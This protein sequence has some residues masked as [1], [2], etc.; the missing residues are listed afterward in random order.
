MDYLIIIEKK[1]KLSFHV[2][3]CRDKK[4]SWGHIFELFGLQLAIL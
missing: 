2:M 3:N 1:Q 4:E